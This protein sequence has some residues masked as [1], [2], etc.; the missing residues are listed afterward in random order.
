MNRII[1]TALAMVMGLS[2]LMAHEGMWMMNMLKK[3]N[4]AEM[5]G[6]GLELSAD[7]IYNINQSSVKDAIGRMNF[8]ARLAQPCIVV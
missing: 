8:L 6:L 1:T 2:G 3:I 5:Q 7:D 4:E